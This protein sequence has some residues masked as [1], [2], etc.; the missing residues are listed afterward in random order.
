MEEQRVVTP[1]IALDAGKD[2]AGTRKRTTAKDAK[3]EDGIEMRRAT[4]N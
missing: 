4:E 3:M 1:E 2:M